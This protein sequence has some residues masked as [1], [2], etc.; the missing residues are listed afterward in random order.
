MESHNVYLLR[1]KTTFSLIKKQK[2]WW[3][4]TRIWKND[5]VTLTL[6]KSTFILTDMMWYPRKDIRTECGWKPLNIQPSRG[7]SSKNHIL[8][9]RCFLTHQPDLPQTYLCLKNEK[10]A[11]K[12]N[13]K[14]SGNKGRSGSGCFIKQNE[15]LQASTCH[16]MAN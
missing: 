9:G 5:C 10:N 13:M 7:E 16:V 4:D 1:R 15:N 2:W 8:V 3:K 6:E 14:S 11:C 12:Q